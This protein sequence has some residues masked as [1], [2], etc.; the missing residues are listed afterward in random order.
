MF[1]R[2]NAG[3]G[4]M[5]SSE[6]GLWSDEKRL[7]AVAGY[8]A[9]GSIAAVHKLTGIPN[10]TLWN[11]KKYSAWWE[12]V[13]TS[14]REE[15][16]AGTSS[17]IS[18][19]LEKALESI[20]E[21]IEGG[22]TVYNARTGEITRVPVTAASLNKIA[23]TLLDRRL[24]LDSMKSSKE[25]DEV[26]ASDKLQKQLGKLATAFSKFVESQKREEKVIDATQV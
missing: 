25:V 16:N 3:R 4:K 22:D 17:K 21:R 26:D 6:E 2:N 20:N 14:L 5:V 1:L 8:I 11:W 12:E 24:V 23:S 13:E 18:G 9:T 15:L 7:E 10:N 19:I